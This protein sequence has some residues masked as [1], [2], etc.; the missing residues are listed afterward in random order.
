MAVEVISKIKPKNNGAF[1]IADAVDVEYANDN[2]SVGNVKEA[3]DTLLKTT[4]QLKAGGS[5]TTGGS[6]YNISVASKTLYITN[7]NSDA[8]AI[9][10]SG[11]ALKM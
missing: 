5:G 11:H 6:G 4:E 3:L 7:K 1:K 2:Y 8:P 10:V 9:R